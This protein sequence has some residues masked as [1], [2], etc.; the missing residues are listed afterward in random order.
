M[1][2]RGAGYQIPDGALI[3]AIAPASLG[4]AGAIGLFKSNNFYMPRL[5]ITF[6]PTDK[7]VIRSGAGMFDNINHLNT[8]TIFNLMPPKSG[9]LLFN[10]VTDVAQNIPVTGGAGQ[11][12]TLQMRIFRPG[13]PILTLNDPLRAA[14]RPVAL[15]YVPPDYKHGDVWKWSF[16]I[17]RELPFN[18]ALTIGYVGSKGSHT[19]NSVGNYNQPLPSPDTNVQARRPY[20][21]FYDPA[22]PQNGVQTLSTIRYID[23]YGENFHHG[24]QVKADRRFSRGLAFGF[25]YTSALSRANLV[26]DMTQLLS[27]AKRMRTFSN[28]TLV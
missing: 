16:D 15:N 27:S 13:Q 5:G 1:K 25:A 10:S 17:Q 9:S 12:V 4:D 14:A 6:R 3:P 22:V 2:G 24:L 20:Q 7:W 26:Y 21:Q 11:P 19:G 8:W 28:W 18:A 23:S